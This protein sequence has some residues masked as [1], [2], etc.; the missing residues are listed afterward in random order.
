[1][2]QTARNV[3]DGVCQTYTRSHAFKT[4]LMRAMNTLWSQMRT[5]YNKR[6]P[7]NS[8]QPFVLL[9]MPF[10]SILKEGKPFPS[11]YIVYVSSHLKRY[12][13]LTAIESFNKRAII[14]IIFFVSVEYIL[15]IIKS[16]HFINVKPTNL[17]HCEI[18][19]RNENETGFSRSNEYVLQTLKKVKK[20][21]VPLMLY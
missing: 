9:Q 13:L 5:F 16:T 20:R 12:I 18:S 14:G 8:L 1:M 6:L 17:D 7:W 4:R 2:T 21:R 10:F 3:G 19:Q 15:F 11:L